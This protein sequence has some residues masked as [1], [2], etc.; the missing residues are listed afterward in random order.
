MSAPIFVGLRLLAAI[1]LY[2]FVGWSFYL[3]WRML[4]SQTDFLSSKKIPA[5]SILLPSIINEITIVTFEQP[6]LIVGRDRDCE[7]HLDDSAVSARHARFSFHHGHWWVEDSGS[8]NGT[9]LNENPLTV[10]TIVTNG[11]T[12]SCGNTVLTIS[13]PE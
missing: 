12:I 10:P 9:T 13:L 6:E 2:A 11:D 4:K 3:M 5:L 1:L 8:K 7:I